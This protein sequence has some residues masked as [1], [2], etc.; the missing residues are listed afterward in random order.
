MRRF[1][2][3]ILLVA[4]LVAGCKKAPAPTAES[5]AS[6]RPPSPYDTGAPPPIVVPDSGD[7]NANLG[8]L[9][10]ALRKYIAGTHRLP[11]DFDDFVAKS[12]VQPPPPPVGKKYAI[13]GQVIALVNQ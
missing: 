13:Q 5:L 2:V 6:R 9:S 11:K 1:A 10:L 12:G 3:S 8:Q 4:A 7:V